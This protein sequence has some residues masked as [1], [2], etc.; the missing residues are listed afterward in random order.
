MRRMSSLT[1]VMFCLLIGPAALANGDDDDGDGGRCRRI[2]AE[3]DLTNGTIEGNFGLDGTV[4][5][6]ADSRG[7]VPTTAPPGSSV[8]SGIL[9]IATARGNLL[10][11]ETGMFSSRTGNPGGSVLASWGDALSGTERFTGVTGDLFFSGRI[12]G[13]IFLVDVSGQLCRP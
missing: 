5:F 4:A 6:A 2:R 12:A 7:I 1:F 10:V 11:R 9:T 3:I 8:F 13:A